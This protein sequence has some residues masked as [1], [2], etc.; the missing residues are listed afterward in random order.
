MPQY[1]REIILNWID[2]VNTE[3]KNLS[4]WEEQY[5]ES[6]TERTDHGQSLSEKQVEILERI[7]CEKVK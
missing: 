6:V 7:Y 1:K 4:K 5:M 3:G 2:A